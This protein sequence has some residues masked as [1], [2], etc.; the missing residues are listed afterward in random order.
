[1]VIKRNQVKVV[2]RRVNGRQGEVDVLDLDSVSFRAWLVSTLIRAG[3][4]QSRNLQ[5]PELQQAQ[6]IELVETRRG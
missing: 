6:T 3:I 4:I 2:A 5:L 1:M